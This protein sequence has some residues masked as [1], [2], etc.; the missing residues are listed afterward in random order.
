MSRSLRRDQLVGDLRAE[1]P[2]EIK[3]ADEEREMRVIGDRVERVDLHREVS[4]VLEELPDHGHRQ[5]PFAQL[6]HKRTLVDFLVP[7]F[8]ERQIEIVYVSLGL[9][10]CHF[11]AGKGLLDF[12]HSFLLASIFSPKPTM[13]PLQKPNRFFSASSRSNSSSV[14]FPPDDSG[15]SASLRP[16]LSCFAQGNT[17][18]FQGCPDDAARLL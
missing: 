6:R 10:G 4:P 8:V 11:F 7:R 9:R 1:G 13:L 17:K 5:F 2:Q 16:L 14:K 18:S 12:G 3:V 15:L